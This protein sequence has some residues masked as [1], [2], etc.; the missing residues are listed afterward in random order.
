MSVAEQS[1]QQLV[2]SSF[3]TSGHQE[4]EANHEAAV[5]PVSSGEADPVQSL[6]HPR[7]CKDRILKPP[8]LFFLFSPN[9]FLCSRPRLSCGSFD[10]RAA[11]ITALSKR[12]RALNPGSRWL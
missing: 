8:R 11:K 10:K 6:H 5:R 2:P 3:A 1:E 9:F 4:R 7:H 12:L